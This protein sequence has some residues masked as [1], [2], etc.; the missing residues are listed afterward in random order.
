[1]RILQVCD[2]YQYLGGTETYIINLSRDLEAQGHSISVMYAIKT[3]K[4]FFSDNRGEHY[5]A[6]IMVDEKLSLNQEKEIREI[7][8]KENPD[9]IYIHNVFNSYLID[10]LSK[11]RP[12]VRFIHDHNIFCPKGDKF[13]DLKGKV[14][15]CACGISCFFNAYINRCLPR[16]PFKTIRLIRQKRRQAGINKKINIIVASN[17]MKGCL[18]QNGFWSAKIKVIS[19]YTTPIKYDQVFF[20]DFLL[21]VGR[22]HKTKGLQILLPALAKSSS[23][24]KLV[25]I[26]EG[27]YMDEAKSLASKLKLKN[28][29]SFLG[30]LS[31][32][33]I[34]EYFVDCFALVISSRW[35]EPFGIVG[36]EAMSYKKPVIASDVGGICDWLDDNTNGFLVDNSDAEKLAEKIKF[37]YYNKDKAKDMGQEGYKI[38]QD[39]F[40][41]DTHINNLIGFFNELKQ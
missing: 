19:Y 29:V 31:Q 34:V 23:N 16:N 35:P 15:P 10:K 38:F 4:T 25:V 11:M 32:E 3:D 2:Y 18:I 22:V 14:C 5:F 8:D 27:R 26:G 28:R 7:I 41:K 9:I 1:M 12:V 24:I 21:F 30:Q 20:K 33:K 6:A 39:K 13:L 36:I 17:Y 37:L 40:S